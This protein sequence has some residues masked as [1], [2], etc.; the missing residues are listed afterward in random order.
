M[1]NKLMKNKFQFRLHI[2]EE[3]NEFEVVGIKLLKVNRERKKLKAN[4]SV[5]C[6]PI[7]SNLRY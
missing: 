7:S 4:T 5:T 3:N 6:W 1:K 2:A